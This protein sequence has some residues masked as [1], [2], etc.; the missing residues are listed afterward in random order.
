MTPSTKEQVLVGSA[1]G[2]GLV[3]EILA[4]FQ[5]FA[6]GSKIAVLLGGVGLVLIG[7]AIYAFYGMWHSRIAEPSTRPSGAYQSYSGPRSH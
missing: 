4:I 5:V 3:A 7:L 6:N 2:G 1:G